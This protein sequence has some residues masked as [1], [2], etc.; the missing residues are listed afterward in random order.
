MIRELPDP[1]SILLALLLLWAP[2]PFGSVTP[3][4]SSLLQGAAFLALTLAVVTARGWRE[5]RAVRVPAAAM[6]A[7]ALLGLVQSAA[8]PPS[9]ISRLSSGH[10]ELYAGAQA[11][12]GGQ[13]V[14]YSL[15]LSSWASRSAA[16]SWAAAAALLAAAAVA[17]GWRGNRRLLGGALGLAALFQVIFGARLWAARAIR[18]WGVELPGEPSRLRGTFVNPNHLACFLEI[19]LAVT[20][21]LAWW[22]LARARQEEQP[23]RKLILWA[24]PIL[25]WLA[26]FTGLAF[27]GSRAGLAAALAAAAVQGALVAAMTRSLRP[28]VLGGTL[29]AAGLGTVALVGLWEGFGRFMARSTFD[30]A[31]GERAQVYAASVDLWREFPWLGTGLGTFREAFPMVQPPGLAGAWWHAHSDPLELLVTAGLVGVVLVAAGLAGLVARLRRVLLA[32]A[33]SEDRAAALAALGALAAVG[34]HELVDFGLSL[35]ANAAALAVLCG[36]AAGAAT[37]RRGSRPA[38]PHPAPA[39]REGESGSPAGGSPWRPPGAGR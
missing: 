19:A 36:A 9:W 11:V 15:S 6:V 20:F 32:G 29:A 38:R 4:S 12:A 28:L 27:T 14:A 39:V 37:R 8:W 31:L 3:S 24:G 23:E 5:L 25:L 35:P 26:L 2:L 34:V 33:R 22:S 13:A 30:V 16:L 10:A 17:G 1:A 21:A 18:L 7:V